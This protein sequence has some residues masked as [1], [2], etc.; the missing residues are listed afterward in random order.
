M[1]RF[2]EEQHKVIT[3]NTKN[4]KSNMDR[5]IDLKKIAPRG[6]ATNLKSNM[7]RFI[8]KHT[9]TSAHTKSI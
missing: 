5:F 4:L 6:S 3:H 2:I 1:D 8:D 7:D 9:T